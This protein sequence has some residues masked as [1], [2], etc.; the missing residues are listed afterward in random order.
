MAKPNRLILAKEDILA[1]FS[2]T[3][4]KVYA[5]AQ[6][7]NVLREKRRSWHLPEN[8]TVADFISF[9][10]KYGD[11]RTNRLSSKIYGR[12]IIRYSW[13]KVSVLELAISTSSRGYLCHVTG[14]CS[15]A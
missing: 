9:L 15:M 3:S 6:L 14:S 7:T 1:T 13:G 12:Q 5:K 4:Q 8:T 11:L 2:L 10:A